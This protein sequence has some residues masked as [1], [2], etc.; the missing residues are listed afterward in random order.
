[1]VV[2]DLGAAA[3]VRSTLSER[4]LGGAAH[5]FRSTRLRQEIERFDVFR[6]YGGEVPT[7]GGNDR[8]DRAP[9][10]YGDDA[11]VRAADAEP[12]RYY[13]IM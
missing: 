7:V 8:G 3:G 12:K 10:G 13:V 2:A 4:R 5:P 9:F 6:A 11:G 1:V